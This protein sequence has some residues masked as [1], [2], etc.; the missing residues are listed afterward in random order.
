[1]IIQVV[2]DTGYFPGMRGAFQ[3]ATGPAFPDTVDLETV[4]DHVADDPAMV[5]LVAALFEEIRSYA[6]NAK[7]SS[8]L[9][10]EAEQRWS[11]QQ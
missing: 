8:G 7:E 3:I 6:R 2:P 10:T 4:E 9:L 11:Q 5:G 1:V